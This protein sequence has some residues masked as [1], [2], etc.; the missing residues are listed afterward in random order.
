MVKHESYLFQW[1]S[2]QLKFSFFIS[3]ASEEV[4]FQWA[5]KVRCFLLEKKK[6]CWLGGKSVG[7]EVF[8]FCPINFPQHVLQQVLS[9]PSKVQTLPPSL[10][11]AC[12]RHLVTLHKK[13]RRKKMLEGLHFFFLLQH[14]W[15]F[16]LWMI[17]FTTFWVYKRSFINPQSCKDDHS[18]LKMSTML[19]QQ[20][21][22]VNLPASFFFFFSCVRGN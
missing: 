3:F 17:V 10:P 22:N 1:Q 4:Y 13:R 20:K 12:W 9:N 18:Q 2:F 11:M 16:K 21:T 15:H 6:E 5:T 19:Q 8:Y 7:G 14:G